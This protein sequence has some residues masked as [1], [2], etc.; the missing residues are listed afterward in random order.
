MKVLV[1]ISDRAIPVFQESLHELRKICG[2]RELLPKS[3]TLSESLLG[4]VY[5]G[6]FNGSKVRI[7]RIRAYSGGDPQKVKEVCA[8]SYAPLFSNTRSWLSQTFH[9]VA[10]ILKRS[11][12]PNIVPLL[13]VTI[14]PLELISDWMPG[15]DL[16]GYIA[17]HPNADRLSLVS[18]PSTT[19]LCDAVTPHQLS[20]V[21]EGLNYLH[22]CDVIHG[23]LKG[24]CDRSRFRLPPHSHPPSRAFSWTRPTV[25]ESQILVL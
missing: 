2:L 13:G 25:H 21:A 24:V 11:A 10:V 6:T 19:A 23:D 3:W 8:R 20:D 18:T 9:K 4:C 15:G 22:S 1:G 14:E 7:R 16:P 17:M 12:H 5:K